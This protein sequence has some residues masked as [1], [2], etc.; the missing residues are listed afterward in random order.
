MPCVFVFL[1]ILPPLFWWILSLLSARSF[2]KRI[3]PS[4]SLSSLP[5]L[6]PLTLFKP[7]PPDLN[8]LQKTI[9][10]QAIHSFAQQL[11]SHDELL[12]LCPR[13]DLSE[14]QSIT[15]AWQTHADAPSIR[16][17][18]ETK[19]HLIYANPKINALAQLA[20]HATHSLWWWSDADITL[21]PQSADGIRHE[22]A[23]SHATLQTQAYLIP[24]VS[25]PEDFLDAC[26]IH[27]ELFPGLALLSR[28][29][30]RVACG[31]S[32]L[33]HKDSLGKALSWEALG[34]AFA[35]DNLMGRTLQPVYF[36]TTFIHTQSTD[37]SLWKSWL[38]YFRWQKTIRWCQPFGFLG[39]FVLQ[40]WL[41]FAFSLLLPFP[42]WASGLL[43][44]CL[45]AMET[46]WAGALFFLLGVF[47][48]SIVL[49]SPLWSLLRSIAW[50]L[51]WL[52][53][54]VVW[55]GK[56]WLKPRAQEV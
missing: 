43:F 39:L 42:L 1:L 48:R 5:P 27:L 15:R 3:S 25:R 7:L 13:K 26:F 18:P 20:P 38:H 34:G 56:K 52:P 47:P 36:G 40:P 51:C 44:F 23:L 30:P 8:T 35:D 17:F 53:I 22:F 19:D 10:I 41:L 45:L 37:I 24:R 49:L 12:I 33:F 46:L 11:H 21:P 28:K 55:S 14:W 9:H 16:V 4:R 54:P 29:N 2:L 50:I 31:G 6:P 32:L